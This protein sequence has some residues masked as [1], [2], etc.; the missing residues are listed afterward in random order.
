MPITFGGIN[1]GL[2]P[3][4]VDQLVEAERMPIKKLEAAKGKTDAKL[5]LVNELDGKIR[6]ISETLGEVAGTKGFTKFKLNS[7]DESVIQGSVDPQSRATGSWNLEAKRLANKA[8]AVSNGFPDKDKTEIGVGYFKFNTAD[9]EKEVYLSGGN[10]SLEAAAM[11]INQA[12]IGVRASVIQDKTDGDNPYR[13]MISGKSLGN[14][15]EVEFPLLYFLDGDQD[16]YFDRE[17][18]A[19]NGLINIDGFDM[20][21]QD[22]EIKD[23]IPGVTLEL[24][25]AAPGKVINVNIREDREQVVGK[26]KT[27]VESM[28]EVLGFIQGQLAVSE[29]TDT[30]QTLGGDGTLRNIESDLRRYLQN[31][32]YGIAGDIKSLGQMGITFNRNGRLDFSEE[33]FNSAL[34]KSPQDV[35]RFLVGDGGTDGFIPGIRRKIAQYTD[36]YFG[37]ISNKK[38]GL[39][40]QIA[41][42]DQRI[43][44]M[45]RRV[46]A[47]E[48]VLRQK[49]SNLEDKMARI[50]QQGAVLQQRLGGGG[51]ADVNLGGMSMG[52]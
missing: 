13:L 22:N 17:V 20:E 41:Q 37:P 4:L 21:I 30:T 29:K 1:T 27:F 25:Q 18:K 5:K 24:R 50:K 49:F 47:R 32:Q 46:E 34:S 38:R 31:P 43:E 45:Q 48:R 33:K 23:M 51:A 44:G 35:E 42:A 7:G 28:N 40:D 19:Q 26:I 39:Q 3:N 52:G 8:G 14:D 12:G 9:G 15:N 2:P 36:G 10:S 6:K 11:T 16:F